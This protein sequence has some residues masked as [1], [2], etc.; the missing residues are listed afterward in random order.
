VTLEPRDPEPGASETIA[1]FGAVLLAAGR[2]RRF[3]RP[4]LLMPWR[5]TSIL[6]YSL[7]LWRSLGA[8]QIAVVC[9]SHDELIQRE[10]DRLGFPADQRVENPALEAGMF[11]SVRCAAAWSGWRPGL[12]SYTIILGDQPH[13]RPETI[14]SLLGFSRSRPGV[15]CQ[16]ARLGHP[17]HP[18]VLPARVF[19]ALTGSRAGDLREFLSAVPRALCELDDGGLDLDIDTPA[20]YGAAIAANGL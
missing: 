18:V 1:R 17:R 12:G 10:L 9:A 13:L 5:G 20:D 16:P 6:G 8:E 4:K 19:A 7:Q 14:R 15:V 11:G 3:G 2:S